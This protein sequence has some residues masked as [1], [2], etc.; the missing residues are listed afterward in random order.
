M[1]GCSLLAGRSAMHIDTAIIG[2][3]SWLEKQFSCLDYFHNSSL[4][5]VF[6]D[7]PQST[8]STL[9]FCYICFHFYCSQNFQPLWNK[10][11]SVRLFSAFLGLS[12]YWVIRHTDSL[13]S[14]LD[15]SCFGKDLNPRNGEGTV[16]FLDLKA[17]LSLNVYVR[18]CNY[19]WLRR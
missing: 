15:T 11:V 13:I 3:N 10:Q 8:T 6:I 12:Q 16:K 4:S 19:M 14:E 1:D 9:A 17:F 18:V 5:T 7:N 2:K